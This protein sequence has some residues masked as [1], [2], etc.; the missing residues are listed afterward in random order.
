ME[1]NM[2]NF[3]IVVPLLCVGLFLG[4][5]LFIDIG[6]RIGAR[7]RSADPDGAHLG[8]GVVDGAVFTLLALIIA[9][10]FSGAA[11]RFDDRRHLVVEE[12]NDIGTAWLR[13]DLLPADAQ[14]AVRDLFRQYLDSRLATYRKISD[15]DAARAEFA[16]SVKLQHE[17]WALAVI[18][19]RDSGSQ[20]AHV[21]LLP[22]L[23]AMI[24][25]TTTRYMAGYMH[26]PAII[27]VMLAVLALAGSMLVGYS[28]AGGKTR[29]WLHVV[30]FAFVMAATVYVIVDIEY[31]RL[32][33]IR[34]DAIDQ[35]LVELRQ[36]MD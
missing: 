1:S 7:Q 15:S 16:R 12:A 4:M 33:L 9:F 6:R 34:V 30:S 36:S 35:V 24:D 8:V 14:P 23:N 3:L 27:Y 20:P 31:P 22:A 11:S 18:A 5:L 26:P 21:V 10:T 17:I 19:A 25:I 13:I 32:G 28:M 29:S 2:D